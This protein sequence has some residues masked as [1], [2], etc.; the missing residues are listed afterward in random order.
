MR[1]LWCEDRAH[2][3]CLPPA[4]C[5]TISND[6]MVGEG[7]LLDLDEGA[8]LLTVA[9]MGAAAAERPRIPMKVHVVGAPDVTDDAPSS[10]GRA[11]DHWFPGSESFPAPTKRERLK[12][13]AMAASWYAARP[14]IASAS[15]GTCR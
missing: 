8:R 5:C 15:L 14:S 1:A 13:V 7:Q 3:K 12:P 2:T 6:A 10:S 9:N 4:S 11:P